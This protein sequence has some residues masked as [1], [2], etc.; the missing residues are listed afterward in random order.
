[1]RYTTRIQEQETEIRLEGD[2]VFG[3]EQTAWIGGKKYAVELVKDPSGF[4]LRIENKRYRL[5]D[6]EWNG[7]E[8]RFSIHGFAHSVLVK[9]ERDLLLEKLG[10]SSTD[11]ANDR[12]IKAPMPGKVLSVLVKEGDPVNLGQPLVILEAMKMENELKAPV[13][14]TVESLHVQNGQTVEKNQPILEIITR[15]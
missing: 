11:S 3:V 13:E 1:M 7:P 4:V 14:G 15:G 2:L 8:V 6:V 9:D 10:F 5:T 12:Y